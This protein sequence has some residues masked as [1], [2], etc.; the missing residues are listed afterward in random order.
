MRDCD[1]C[2]KP[3]CST[4]MSWFNTQMICPDCDAAE[5][6]RSDIEAAKEAERDACKRGDFN[7]P[8][9]EG[10]NNGKADV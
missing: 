6:K 9:I 2:R 8:G 10:A 7:Y 1:R 3:T 5:H 4:T